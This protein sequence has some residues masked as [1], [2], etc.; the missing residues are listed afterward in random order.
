MK[1]DFKTGLL[2]AGA[3]MAAALAPLGSSSIAVVIAVIATAV[4]EDVAM[5]T[6]LLVGGYLFISIVGQVPVAFGFFGTTM[7]GAATL[8]P[9]QGQFCCSAFSI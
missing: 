1:F 9:W 6:K 7:S 3:F 8:G 4:G 5:V 2:L